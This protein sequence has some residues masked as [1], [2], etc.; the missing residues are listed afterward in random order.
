MNIHFDPISYPMMIILFLSF[1]MIIF[2][3]LLEPRILR[4][5]LVNKNEHGSSKFADIKE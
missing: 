5:K 2:L 4:R 1:G 3:L